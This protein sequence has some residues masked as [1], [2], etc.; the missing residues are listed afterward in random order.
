L[1]EGNT[2]G[3]NKVQIGQGHNMFQMKVMLIS[4][5]PIPT[6]EDGICKIAEDQQK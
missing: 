4:L 2:K 5:N 6:L 1:E 3:L